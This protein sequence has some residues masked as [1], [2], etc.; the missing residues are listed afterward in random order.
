MA[1]RCRFREL[2]PR[3]HFAGKGAASAL[4]GIARGEG[5]VREKL[6][7]LTRLVRAWHKPRS[8]SG[9]AKAQGRLRFP[10]P[11]VKA[12]VVFESDVFS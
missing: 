1:S 5:R 12:R 7:S 10:R 6:K 2:R 8:P 9:R 4:A 11:S 3:S